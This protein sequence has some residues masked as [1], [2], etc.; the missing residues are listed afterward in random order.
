MNT[1]GM[2]LLRCEDLVVIEQALLTTGLARLVDRVKHV[3]ISRRKGFGDS[4]GTSEQPAHGDAYTL[5]VQ[6]TPDA[7]WNEYSPVA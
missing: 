3:L 1:V 6:A 7:A 5:R 2:R 4:R